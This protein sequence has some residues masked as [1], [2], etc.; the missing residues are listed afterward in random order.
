MSDHQGQII[1][2]TTVARGPVVISAV[3]LYLLTYDAIDVKNDD[4]H[5]TALSALIQV[6]VALIGM[7][8]KLSFEPIVW[9]KGWGITL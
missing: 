9:E 2:P 8:R 1:L 5:A 3:I 4:N 7:I 6:R